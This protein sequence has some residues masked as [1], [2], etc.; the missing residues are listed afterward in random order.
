MVNIQ[1]L[2]L[3]FG[4]EQAIVTFALTNNERAAVHFVPAIKT[5]K[6]EDNYLIDAPRPEMHARLRFV[7]DRTIHAAIAAAIDSDAELAQAEEKARVA[8]AE[9]T[10]GD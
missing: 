9:S 1:S 6:P 4:D 10:A 2:T 7:A 5:G 8:A 3:H